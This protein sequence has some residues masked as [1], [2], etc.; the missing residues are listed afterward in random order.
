M[1]ELDRLS[2]DPDRLIAR[3]LESILDAVPDV[4]GDE[5]AAIDGGKAQPWAETAAPPGR[6]KRPLEEIVA[7]YAARV[8]ADPD[9]RAAQ[10]A[11][12]HP[13]TA[14]FERLE[15]VTTQPSRRPGR[16][17]WHGGRRR[18]GGGGGRGA[19][20]TRGGEQPRR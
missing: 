6:N 12:V 14:F 9:A 20:G 1:S 10:P 8:A 16:R 3:A 11:E 19:R 2:E 18:R 17:R 7:E 5:L 15:P 4:H 13:A